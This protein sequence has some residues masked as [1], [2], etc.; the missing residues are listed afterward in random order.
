MPAALGLI[1]SNVRSR[2]DFLDRARFL[3]TFLDD[4]L[5]FFDAVFMT[6]PP[7][8]SGDVRERTA[9]PHL[10]SNRVLWQ[11]FAFY[12][13]ILCLVWQE[14]EILSSLLFILAEEVEEYGS[15]P[16]LSREDL[17][18]F[19]LACRGVRA[20]GAANNMLQRT[21]APRRSLKIFLV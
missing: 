21:L 15:W 12:L 11:I 16:H 4:L 19:R 8:L 2:S 18:P 3:L 5:R 7:G 6:F 17:D 1:I 10:F 20:A 13:W 9:A 14:R